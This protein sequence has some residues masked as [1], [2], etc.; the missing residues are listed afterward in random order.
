MRILL[1][2]NAYSD[3]RRSGRWN[4]VIATAA[5][6]LVPSIVLG[7]LRYGFRGAAK[8]AENEDKLRVF[9]NHP[10]VRVITVGETTSRI[11]ADLKHYLRTT[12]HPIPENDVWIAAVAVETMSTLVTGDAHFSFL[13]QVAMAV[14]SGDSV[15]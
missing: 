9:L 3:W 12:G 5:E 4:Q 15:V 14:E 1:D 8:S 7:E 10:L 6:V 11:Y 13:P 2:T